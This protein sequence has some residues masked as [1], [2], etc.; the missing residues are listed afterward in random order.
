[1]KVCIEQK[2][3][4]KLKNNNC[5]STIPSY[6]AVYIARQLGLDAYGVNSDQRNYW[7][8]DKYKTREIAARVKDYF[9]VNLIKP[10]PKHLGDT[11]PVS[12]NGIVTHDK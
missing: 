1:M 6:E 5:N 2:R 8:I 12:G 9:N 4:L 10:K 3:F 7:G 11:I